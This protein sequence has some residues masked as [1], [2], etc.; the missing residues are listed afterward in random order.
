MY[1][2][3]V[4]GSTLIIGNGRSVL[5]S[6]VGHL[7]DN[8]GSV[9]RFNDYQTEGFGKHVG[10]KTTLWVLSDWVCMKLINKY[11]ARTVPILICI[12]FKFMGKPYYASRRAEVEADLTPEQMR[13]VRFIASDTAEDL[14]QQYSF[15]DS[16]PSSG[17]LTIW[18]F[19]TRRSRRRR[20]SSRRSRR[21]SRRSSCCRCC[22]HALHLHGSGPD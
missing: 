12:P 17:L 7:V 13:R 8:Y 11:P 9:V 5:H 19:C 15:G 3:D 16:W 2:H 20:R 10:T 22:L 14:I 1:R 4:R 18:T 21:S 6:N